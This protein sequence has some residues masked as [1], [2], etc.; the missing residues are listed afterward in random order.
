MGNMM[1][2]ANVQT[3]WGRLGNTI[4]KRLFVLI[5]TARDGTIV[6]DYDAN[7]EYETTN[8]VQTR[9][10][11]FDGAGPTIVDGML[12]VYSGYGFAG[13]TADNALSA[14]SVDRK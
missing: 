7:Q 1:C 10:G 14:F 12:Y 9:G 8:G 2:L 11:S 6:W 5:V 13:G 4:G 3:G